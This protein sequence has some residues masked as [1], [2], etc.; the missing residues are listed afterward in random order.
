MIYP[1]CSGATLAA[2]AT[3]RIVGRQP[4]ADAPPCEPLDFLRHHDLIPE[5]EAGGRCFPRCIQ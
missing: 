5:I 4:D 1:S 3:A 2:T